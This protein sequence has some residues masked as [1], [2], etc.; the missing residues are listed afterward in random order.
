M[1]PIGTTLLVVVVIALACAIFF[2]T[3]GRGWFGHRERPER[4]VGQRVR[5]VRAEGLGAAP[6]EIPPLRVDSFTG[7]DYRLT[8]DTPYLVDGVREHF[9]LARSRHHGYPLSGAKR[10]HT[11]VGCTL[12]SGK[13]F[14]AEIEL[15][16]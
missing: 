14:I 3:G 9:V 5:L 8:F 4:L 10:R 16:A 13:G 7:V 11:A 2:G 15:M 6:P 12:E 1:D